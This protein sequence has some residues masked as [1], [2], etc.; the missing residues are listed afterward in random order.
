MAAELFYRRR[1][2]CLL[3]RQ[4]GNIQL[5]NEVTY[6]SIRRVDIN[7][8][9]PRPFPLEALATGQANSRS[10]ASDQRDFALEA[11]VSTHQAALWAGLGTRSGDRSGAGCA[12]R[13]NLP[14][15][16]PVSAPSSI[17]TSPATIVA[18]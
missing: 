5:G 1:D 7:A 16:A 10:G 15:S 14:G 18:R 12:P 4:I 6:R 13:I 11:L 17:T 9:N 2:N 8:D 3:C